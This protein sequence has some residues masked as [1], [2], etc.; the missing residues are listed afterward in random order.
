MRSKWWLLG[1][2]IMVSIPLAV[3]A[4]WTIKVDPFF[5]Y[6]KPDK[7]TY[8][9][10]LY[11]ERSQNNGISRLFEYEGIITGTSMTECF[12]TTEAEDLFGYTF[13]KVPFSGGTYKEINDNI[14]VALDSNKNIKIIIRGL[15]QRHIIE[16]KNAMRSDLGNYPVYIM[17][18]NPL[19][20]V[21]YLFNRDVATRI[22]KMTKENATEGFEPGITSF[23][24]YSNWMRNCVF[25][26]QSLYPHGI[27]ETDKSVEQVGLTS[28]ER[29]MIVGNVQQNVT[30]L[31]EEN[32]DVTFYYFF[33]PYSGA[34]R[35]SQINSG[36]FVKHIQAEEIVIKEIMKYENIK[37]FSFNNL[38][39]ITNDLNNYKD[40]MHYA[41]WINSL[42]LRYMKDDKYLIT[43]QNYKQYLEKEKK[44]YWEFNYQDYYN[45]QN[46]YESDYYA[47]ALLNKSISNVDPLFLSDDEITGLTLNN[48]SIVDNQ[49]NGKKGILC[50]GCLGSNPS[51]H[52]SSDEYSMENYVG[53]KYV[54][55]EVGKHRYLVLYGRK[56]SD[57]GQPTICIYDENNTIIEKVTKSYSEI[58]NE[59]HQY[60]LDVSSVEGKA[61]V[62]LNGGCIENSG[63]A[64]SEYVFSDITLY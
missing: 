1:F 64:N 19:N 4:M 54:I 27:T 22:Y 47:A 50:K 40:E 23:D 24:D 30:R 48:A 55:P 2:F 52:K 21:K 3:A 14:E 18:D 62:I 36:A 29:A 39:E 6:H 51:K 49:H 15:D 46:D 26:K 42:M 5:H 56:V 28:K 16:D 59:W 37:L 7:E 31:A 10:K 33:P 53:A 44:Y 35:Q 41:E 32:P 45:Q 13:I 34:W 58:D 61:T 38:G 9:Y 12:K 11:N 25:G 17:D 8:F 43:K 60:V 20:D 57:Q 63:N